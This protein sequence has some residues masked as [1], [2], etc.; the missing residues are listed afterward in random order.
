MDIGIDLATNWIDLFALRSLRKY[1]ME[2]GC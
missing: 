1:P 2:K